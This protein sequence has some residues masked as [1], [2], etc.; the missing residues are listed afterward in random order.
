LNLD[1]AGSHGVG[2]LNIVNN[3]AL[4]HIDVTCANALAHDQ[5]VLPSTSVFVFALQNFIENW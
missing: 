3:T 4:L 1:S 2:N 5:N